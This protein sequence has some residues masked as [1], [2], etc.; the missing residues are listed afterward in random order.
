MDS[1]D[2]RVCGGTDRYGI[3]DIENGD[4]F[5]KEKE[6]LLTVAC[7]VYNHEKTIENTI[8]GFL[9]QK[10]DFAYEVIIHDDCSTDSSLA[11]IRKYEQLY[12]D[13]IHVISQVQNQYS[14]G[15]KIVYDFIY[16]EARGKYIALC[17][18][19]DY[20]IDENKLQIQVDY[21]EAHP[22]CMMTTHNAINRNCASGND[23]ILVYGQKSGTVGMERNILTDNGH[24][25]TASYVFRKSVYINY[26]DFCSNAP[27]NDDPLRYMCG[28]YGTIFFLAQSQILWDKG[29]LT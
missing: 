19:D 23:E 11:I 26:P 20:W 21:L 3:K 24:P 14:R 12:P 18:G 8:L 7:A 4:Y 25:P 22:E 10:T 5:M 17:E 27:V 2:I 15:K 28:Y 29:F 9:R 1:A 16:P 6:V 13:I